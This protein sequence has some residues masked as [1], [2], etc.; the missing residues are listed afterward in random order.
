MGAPISVI[1]RVENG[2]RV[3]PEGGAVGAAKPR[4]ESP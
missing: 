1:A 2:P 4:P 3:E